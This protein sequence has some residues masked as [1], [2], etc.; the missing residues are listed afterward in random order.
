[1][2][3]SVRHEYGDR[4]VGDRNRETPARRLPDRTS[5][6]RDGG[7][8]LKQEVAH[9]LDKTLGHRVKTILPPTGTRS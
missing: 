7:L 5:L 9:R 8:S 4:V 1:M 6:H 3:Q 2:P